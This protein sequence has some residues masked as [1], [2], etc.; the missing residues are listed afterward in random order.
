MITITANQIARLL[1]MNNRGTISEEDFE[2]FLWN[3]GAEVVKVFVPQD[4]DRSVHTLGLSVRANHCLSKAGIVFIS[5]LMKLNDNEI[6]N[7]HNC[8]RTTLKE[9]RVALARTN[10]V[11]DKKITILQVYS[12]RAQN[13]LAKLGFTYVGQL[14]M[15]TD[16]DMLRQKNCGAKTLEEIKAALAEIGTSLNL[17]DEVMRLGWK[18]PDWRGLTP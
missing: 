11:F 17:K 9:I 15:M 16:R 8:G 10:T 1:N 13:C 18:P 2:R 12:A 14:V 4:S 7:W 3:R 5:Q 6:L